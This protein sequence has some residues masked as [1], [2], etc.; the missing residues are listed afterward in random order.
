MYEKDYIEWDGDI[1]YYIENKKNTK[2]RKY[3]STIYKKTLY[4]NMIL[5]E[6]QVES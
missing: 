6:K 2:K 3:I 4:K 1:S 5:V